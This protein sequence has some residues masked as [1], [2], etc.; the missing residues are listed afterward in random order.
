MVVVVVVVV[1]R[2]V[3]VRVY[4]RYGSVPAVYYFCMY[5]ISYHV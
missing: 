2:I 1:D 5:D 4:G 3:R